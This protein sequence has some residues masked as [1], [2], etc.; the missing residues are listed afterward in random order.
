MYIVLHLHAS[1]NLAERKTS[2]QFPCLLS[3]SVQED[4]TKNR[5]DAVAREVPKARLCQVMLNIVESI[6]LY[7]QFGR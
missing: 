5:L 3:P 4:G 6:V 1:T 7:V 2:K